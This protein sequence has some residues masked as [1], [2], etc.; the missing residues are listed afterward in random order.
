MAFVLKRAPMQ[1]QESKSGID[2]SGCMAVAEEADMPVVPLQHADC[3]AEC[4]DTSTQDL[5]WLHTVPI[6]S[7]AAIGGNLDGCEV[8]NVT[9]SSTKANKHDFN[10]SPPNTRHQFENVLLKGREL[11]AK[12]E[13]QESMSKLIP[14]VYSPETQGMVEEAYQKACEAEAELKYLTM[15]T[16]QSYEFQ[17]K[18]K[19][20]ASLCQSKSPPR[21]PRRN[22]HGHHGHHGTSFSPPLP[23][24]PTRVHS[25]SPWAECVAEC[26]MDCAH[27]RPT[28]VQPIVKPLDTSLDTPLDTSLDMYR[29]E[30]EEQ[31][32]E[33]EEED[34]L[35]EIVALLAATGDQSPT[36]PTAAGAAMHTDV[37]WV[38]LQ[39]WQKE[40]ENEEEEKE[41]RHEERNEML[42]EITELAISGVISEAQAAALRSRL[43][44]GTRSGAD[45]AQIDCGE[46]EEQ[47]LEEHEEHGLEELEA[48]PST[49][50]PVQR[51][52]W[53]RTAPYD[54]NQIDCPLSALK[55]E[56]PGF[57]VSEHLRHRLP[58]AV[59]IGGMSSSL[60]IG[61]M[62][63]SIGGMGARRELE[64]EFEKLDGGKENRGYF[65]RYRY[66][67]PETPSPV[68]KGKSKE[69]QALLL[70][71]ADGTRSMVEA[72]DYG[73]AREDSREPLLGGVEVMPEA[74]SD[75]TAPGGFAWC[76]VCVRV[77]SVLG[78]K[79]QCR[80]RRQQQREERKQQQ[81]QLQHT[82]PLSI[83]T[84]RPSLDAPFEPWG[85][86][87]T[88][89][90]FEL[91]SSS[92]SIPPTANISSGVSSSAF[93]GP[94]PT[95][96]ASECSSDCKCRGCRE[97][98]GSGC[99]YRLL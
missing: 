31:L 41:E 72:I 47:G 14:G 52:A 71:M 18:S 96:D 67:L 90:P 35:A 66:V 80:R 38:E 98:Q 99:A 70:E 39:G 19:L 54:D 62:S 9:P 97:S 61:G 69:K 10:I 48:Q 36:D 88:N 6:T 23:S 65:G 68:K 50:E 91:S 43:R 28:L 2:A 79:D 75:T 15:S 64:E 95:G 89:P 37:A 83:Q 32:V 29:V 5:D 16:P 45:G 20:D 17:G 42:S 73:A 30:T 81:L 25:S 92:P 53:Q 1:H 76:S 59:G 3:N 49:P 7:F 33:V 93:S 77:K 8:H 51:D 55:E 34:L 85:A 26:P 27:Q 86:P 74:S 13:A 44:G 82:G 60:G 21:T 11:H 4:D 84:H 58:P 87:S 46:H 63:A 57:R 22:Q 40:E 24:P 56:V 78:L 12:K 94:S